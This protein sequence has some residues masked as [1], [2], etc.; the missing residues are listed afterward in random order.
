MCCR[1]GSLTLPLT[2]QARTAKLMLLGRFF[3]QFT[4]QLTNAGGRVNDPPLQRVCD[5]LKFGTQK[6]PRSSVA[7]FMYRQAPVACPFS[8]HTAALAATHLTENVASKIRSVVTDRFFC[9]T[10]CPKSVCP[11]GN[12][13]IQDF[14]FPNAHSNGDRSSRCL[15]DRRSP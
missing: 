4:A 12:Q 6:P 11:S 14:I 3:S 10:C 8:H 5:K 15:R 13:I 1:G 2:Q 9:F 7:V